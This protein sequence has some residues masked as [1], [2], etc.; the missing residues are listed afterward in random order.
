MYNTIVTLKK[1]EGRTLKAGGMWV[2]DN[3]I[4]SIMGDFENGDRYH[5]EFRRDGYLLYRAQDRVFF[6]QTHL[7]SFARQSNGGIPFCHFPMM[8]RLSGRD[9]DC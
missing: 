1:G 8:D 7:Y 4:A 2:F 5:P 6:F 9:K 3:E